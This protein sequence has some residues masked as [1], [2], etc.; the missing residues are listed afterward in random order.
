MSLEDKITRAKSTIFLNDLF[1]GYILNKTSIII[2]NTVDIAATNG[3]VIYFNENILKELS[4]E[5]IVFILL[6]ELLHIL[7]RHL[8]IRKNKEQL[9]FNIATDCA[10][11]EMLVNYGYG[12]GSLKPLFAEMFDIKQVNLTS[13]QIYHKLPN[14]MKTSNLL[15]SHDLWEEFEDDYYDEVE[16]SIKEANIKGYT[17]DL[18]TI[19]EK[20]SLK[21][22]KSL[23]SW[24][25]V[26]K[27]LMEKHEKDY[28]FERR[29]YRIKD[30][31]IP[32]FFETEENLIERIWFVV[33]VSGSMYRTD[34]SQYFSDLIKISEQYQ[35]VGCD[36]S[37]FSTKLTKPRRFNNSK[38]IEGIFNSI[39]TTGGTSFNI[40][41]KEML[42]FY[43]NNLPLAIFILTDG[44]APYPDENVSKGIPVYWILTR[45]SFAEPTFG[46]IVKN[47]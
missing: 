35:T 39:Q 15:T 44:Y 17:S 37:F 2:N 4:I 43:P 21:E 5:E 34:M 1:L 23:N 10:I 24:Q 46:K 11:N 28:S 45:N 26:L 20:F 3:S 36:I 42:T 9:K 33:D 32:S 19:N 38:Q 27:E 18:K 40:I 25:N 14:V 22:E 16:K 41:F 12:Y 7:L 8:E 6:H 47:R 30:F 31:F 13:E 29:D